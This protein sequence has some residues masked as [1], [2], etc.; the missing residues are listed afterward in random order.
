VL[1][2]G[3]FKDFAMIQPRLAYPKN[4]PPHVSNVEVTQVETGRRYK[5]ST[6]ILHATLEDGYLVPQFS[7]VIERLSVEAIASAGAPAH[8]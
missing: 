8:P 5:F 6:G 7:Y 1:V 3:W 2:D 4:F